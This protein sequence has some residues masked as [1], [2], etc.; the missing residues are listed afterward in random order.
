LL[1]CS[2]VTS[3]SRRCTLFPYTTLFRAL[4]LEAAL[5]RL[6]AGDG[7]A[8]L[9]GHALEAPVAC[10]G[11]GPLRTQVIREPVIPGLGRARGARLAALVARDEGHPPV[12][13][14]IVPR[15]G[16]AVDAVVPVAQ[17][18]RRAVG[19]L[20]DELGGAAKRRAMLDQVHHAMQ[21]LGAPL[22]LLAQPL[23]ARLGPAGELLGVVVVRAVC[24]LGSVGGEVGIAPQQRH[25]DGIWEPLERV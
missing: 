19:V 4:A 12:A 22:A 18:G 7:P 1:L 24:G 10:R 8:A 13:A 5:E 2:L 25:L 14:A 9:G 23:G 21:E 15:A 20:R 3:H 16:L 17:A 6:A 11:R